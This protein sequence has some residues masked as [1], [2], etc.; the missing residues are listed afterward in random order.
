MI[1]G[2]PGRRIAAWIAG[3][4]LALVMSSAAA[5]S[6]P[7]DTNG[8]AVVDIN[9]VLNVLGNWGTGPFEPPGSDANGDGVVDV[10]DFLDVIGRWGPCPPAPFLD[11][12]GNSGCL[13]DP[14][15]AY[16]P[17][18]EDD[19]FAFVVEGDRLHVV[20]GNATYNCCPEEIAVTLA[21]GEWLLRLTEEEILEMPCDC[22]CCYEVTSTV[23]GLAPGAYTV[24]YRWYDWETGQEQCD[25]AV[26]VVED[27]P[28]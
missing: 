22:M 20:H 15:S 28:G 4:A 18:P 16:E 5:G 8:D 25:V 2:G 3:A 17:C 13:P 27:E 11:D 10:T 1:A 26:V 19:T 6:C 9:D 23:G 12:Y 21:V 14:A 7:G 24:E